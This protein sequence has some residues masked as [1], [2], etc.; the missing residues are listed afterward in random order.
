MNEPLVVAG[1]VAIPRAELRF[2][3][4]RSGGPGGQNINKTATQVELLFD[5]AR[6]PSLDEV[7]RALVR[8]R[9]ANRI[10]AEGILHL[11]SRATRS[12]LENRADV[13]E[14]F[15]SLL[16]RALTPPKPRRPTN[17]SRGAKE[18][19]LLEKKRRGAIK[20]VRRTGAAEQ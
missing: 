3:F 13:T 1:R 17:P 16:E 20:R 5:V 4:A 14:R 11:V 12:Q 9:L 8:A 10:D 18:K 6:S 19:R 2:R 15:V 7:Q